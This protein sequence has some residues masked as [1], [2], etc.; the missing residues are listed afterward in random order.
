MVAP[1]TLFS[2][3]PLTLAM[4]SVMGR[5]QSDVKAHSYREER[6]KGEESEVVFLFG[7]GGC[8]MTGYEREMCTGNEGEREGPLVLICTSD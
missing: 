4:R 3:A 8:M 6:H 5:Y 1:L 7:V 2:K